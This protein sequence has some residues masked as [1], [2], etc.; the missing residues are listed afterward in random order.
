MT[1]FPE[2]KPE[3][4]IEQVV[5]QFVDAQLR[6]ENPNI[7]DFVKQYP[8]L[9]DKIRQRIQ[10]LREI[11]GL[12]AS[13]MQPDDSDFQD[14]PAEHNLIGQKLGDFEI[15]RIIGRGGMGA[16]FL[17][18]QVSLDREVA[19]KVVSDISGARGKTIERFKREAKVLAKISHPNIVPIYEVG[20]EGPYSYFAMEHIKGTSLDKILASI[21]NAKPGDKASDVMHKCLEAQAEVYDGKQQTDSGTRAEI[22]TEYIINISKIIINIASALDYAHKRGILHRDVKPSNILIDS[23]GTPKLVDFGL[24]KAETQQTITISGEFFGTPNYVSPEQIN[25]PETVDCRS[26]VYSLAATY[27]ECLTLHPPFEGNTVNETLTRVISREAIP[28]KKYCPR[29]STDFNTVLMHA[30]EKLPDDRYPTAADFA[31]DIKNLLEFKPI[32]AKKPSI[33][34]RAYKVVRRNPV[35]TV[36]VLV[37]IIA[38]TIVIALTVFYVRENKIA[39]AGRLHAEGLAKMASGHH[40]EAL[41]CFK[42][43]LVK[44]PTHV[45][46]AYL[47]AMCYQELGDP[48]KAILL[49]KH[50]VEIGPNC[51][52]A[53]FGLALSYQVLRRWKE[54]IG[55]LQKA[56]MLEPNNA[57]YKEVLAA[58]YQQ[59]ENYQ[60]AIK[61]YREYLAIK[62]DNASVCNRLGYCCSMY[63]QNGDAIQAYKKAIQ[64]EPKNDMAYSS[65]SWC[66]FNLGEYKLAVNNANEAIKLQPSNIDALKCMASSYLGLGQQNE[67]IDTSKKILAIDTNYPIISFVEA[68]K[69]INRKGA[70]SV[71]GNLKP[72]FQNPPIDP[73]LAEK[74]VLAMWYTRMNRIEDSI[75]AYQEAIKINPNNAITYSLLGISYQAFGRHNEAIDAFRKSIELE[76]NNHF[77][78]ARDLDLARSLTAIGQYQESM[79]YYK[80]YINY[81]PD[82]ELAW[83]GLGSCYYNLQNYEEA[84]RCYEKALQLKPDMVAVNIDLLK[85]YEKLHGYEKIIPHVA[86]IIKI[87]PKEILPGICLNAWGYKISDYADVLENYLQKNATESN[88][89]RGFFKYGLAE[90]WSVLGQQKKA[91]EAYTEAKNIYQ[92][93][94]KTNSDEIY[95]AYILWGLGSSYYG[96]KQYGDAIITYDEAI[97]RDPNFVATYAKKSFLYATCPNDSF[98]NGEKAVKLATKACE[99]TNYES[100]ACIAVLAAAYAESGDFEKAVEYQKKAIELADDSADDSAKKEYEK[101]LEA[102]KANRPWRE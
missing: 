80:Q 66:Y 6:G 56:V 43:A 25:K 5:Q 70:G 102:Y 86:Q 12:F 30:L 55:P 20:E 48:N 23:N 18:R 24:A 32:T 78:S 17:A 42:K 44:D 57:N 51:A 54:S 46:A 14:T 34:Q 29:L 77:Y 90:S 16:V 64:L 40:A 93:L 59:S 1:N 36:T 84:I 79:P 95:D 50:A 71:T 81:D 47:G 37:A 9:E 45:Q 8:G 19:L 26:D 52:E 10:N 35:R 67:F 33:T 97:K 49:Y 91:N 92:Q 101:R 98:R 65:L 99:L 4:D 85:I 60:D 82:S 21:R 13:L 88:Y 69:Y 3:K 2:H 15:V 7:N 76:P 58:G 27:Y 41:V 74:L 73:N 94:R 83:S 100:D 28:P 89:V 31:N 38:T 63:K 53:H 22:D 72:N 11:D 68:Q 75:G 61:T 87:K 39:D 96:L 62:P